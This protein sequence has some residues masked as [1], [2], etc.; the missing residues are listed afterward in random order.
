MTNRKP[1]VAANWKM[2]GSRQ[3]V[4]DMLK[5]VT[6]SNI[7]KNIDVV[8]SPPATLYSY[9]DFTKK[10]LKS[11]VILAAQNINEKDNGA[12]TG[13]LSIHHVKETG[14][15]WAICGHSE[16]RTL[17]GE[18]STITAQ[19]VLKAKSQG[20]K[21]ILCVGETTEEYK[22]GKTFSRLTAQIEAVYNIGGEKAFTDCIIAYEPVW[23]VGTGQAATPELAQEVHHFIRGMI[24][25]MSPVA[26]KSVRI[27]YG[28]SVTPDN[29]A[30]LFSQPDIDGGLIGAAS[31]I[32]EKFIKICQL[33]VVK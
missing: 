32:P 12:I 25:A 33:A 16:R 31:L 10:N 30:A 18:R 5:A 3:L 21:P 17:F 14:C 22:A 29:A 15:Q 7:N 28:G 6:Q 26:G 1:I 23:A 4:D 13:E 19:K 9:L 20:I 2:N 27:L 8:I 24:R 11:D